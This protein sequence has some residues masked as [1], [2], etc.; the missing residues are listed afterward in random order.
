MKL[1]RNFLTNH[2]GE[3]LITDAG[4]YAK[5]AKVFMVRWD[6]AAGNFVAARVP[7]I[8]SDSTPGEL[9]HATFAPIDLPPLNP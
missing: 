7:Y 9:E 1:S 8:R 2:V 5:P 3:L 4:E 6:S